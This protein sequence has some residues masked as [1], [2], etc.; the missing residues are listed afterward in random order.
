MR[1]RKSLALAAASGMAL[2]AS[3]PAVAQVFFIGQV[4]ETGANFCPRNFAS[5]SGQ[6]LSIQQNQAL[7]SLL[8]TTFG[9]NGTTTFQLPDIR[10]RMVIGTGT[11]AGGTVV[12]GQVGGS[13]TITLS[14]A[15][16]PAHIHMGVIQTANANGND[17]KPFR[18]AFA[19]T[20]DNQYKT[21]PVTGPVTPDGFLD[22]ATVTV[23]KTGGDQPMNNMSPFLVTRHCIALQGIFPSR[24]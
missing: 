1:H 20:P 8:G 12:L 7:F 6:L 24:N 2:A 18:N 3:S 13:E 5:A 11:S 22:P 9:G 19:V 16:L 15:N 17:I 14:A 23:Q 4:I 10:G 21:S